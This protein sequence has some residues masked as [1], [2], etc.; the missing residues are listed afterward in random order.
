MQKKWLWSLPVLVLISLCGGLMVPLS[1]QDGRMGWIL[2]AAVLVFAA[3]CLVWRYQE[4]NQGMLQ[5]SRR[6]EELAQMAGE[7]IFEYDY[8][9][10]DLNFL[11]RT[12]ECARFTADAK[13][14]MRRYLERQKDGEVILHL[15]DTAG[16]EYCCK[17]FVCGCRMANGEK[18]SRVLG[19]LTE[20][21][22]AG[23]ES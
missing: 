1:P 7:S 23:L 21:E 9:T 14:E 6:Y 8:R 11:I 4:K 16:R 12:S 3:V 2:A 15:K 10:K 13:L 22:L 20:L 19:K 17:M 18:R 5:M